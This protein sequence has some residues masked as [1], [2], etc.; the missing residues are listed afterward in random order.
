MIIIIHL[1]FM[2]NSFATRSHNG[3]GDPSDQG[4]NMSENDHKY[5][6]F[7]RIS[8]LKI[9]FSRRIGNYIRLL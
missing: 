3:L 5:F 8:I 2:K 4:A 7:F 9:K 1:E 6:T